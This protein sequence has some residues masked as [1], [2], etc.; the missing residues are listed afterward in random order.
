MAIKDKVKKKVVNAFRLDGWRNIMTGLGVKGRDRRT[1]NKIDWNIMTEPE[2]DEL[3]AASDVARKIVDELVDEAFREGYELKAESLDP[4]KMKRVK[5]EDERL[6]VDEKLQEAWKVAR[7]YGGSA[8]IPMPKNVDLLSKPFIPEQNQKFESLLVLSRWELPYAM[9]ENDVRSPNFGWPR[10]YR[11][12]PRSGSDQMNFEVHYTWLVRFDG[13]YLPRQKFLMNNR[14]H[15]SILNVCKIPIRDYDAALASVSA[16]LDDF[17]VAVMKM[18]DLSRTIAEDRDDLITKRLEIANLS[19]SVAKTILLDAEA[20]EFTYQDRQLT[21]VADCVRMVAGRLV[22][23]SNMPHTK[24]LGE[25]PEGSNATGNSTTKDWYDYVGAQQENYLNSRH[26]QLRRA[27][28]ATKQSPT[29]GQVPPDLQA[30]YAPLWQEPESVQAEIRFKQSQT[31]Q[32]YINTAVLEPAEI[33][34]SRFGSGKYSVHTQLVDDRDKAAKEQVKQL[35]DDPNGEKAKQEADA[36]ALKQA[37]AA[38][39]A[40]KPGAGKVPPK[41]AK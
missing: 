36:N 24:I 38:G 26:L 32:I 39:A 28:L 14:W 18:K 16:T 41:K 23:A 5:E 31:D 17:S 30:I 12:N 40:V 29:G 11:I 3:Y 33:A 7:M 13:A 19:R 27:L 22:V 37:K 21:G 4:E 34:V 25:S 9:L 6:Q 1:C 8:I 20:E 2:A 15:D 10:S 35:N